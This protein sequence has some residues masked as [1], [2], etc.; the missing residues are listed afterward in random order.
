M[1]SKEKTSTKIWVTVVS[2]LILAFLLY[3]SRRWIPEAV[4]WIGSVFV[5]VWNWLGAC[6]DIP[7]W[8][9]VI[10]SICGAWVGTRVL[11]SLRPRPSQR[12]PRWRE[13]KE[14]EFLG[15]LWRW[16]YDT[17]GDIFNLFSFCPESGCDMQTFGRLGRYFG[18]GNEST[19]YHCDR[20]GCTPD[21]K[22]GREAIENRVV[23]EVQRLLR[24]NQWKNHIRPNA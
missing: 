17:G 19:I 1:E 8:L 18:D 24:T 9:L 12:E 7:G 20:C 15:V 2:G 4:R 5:A 14:F 16:D 11:A 10:L 21:I 23:R 6:H 22:G 13:F 3:I